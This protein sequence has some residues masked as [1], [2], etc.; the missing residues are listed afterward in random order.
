M[1]PYPP[2]KQYEQYAQSLLLHEQHIYSFWAFPIHI[3]T[4]IYTR[5]TFIF[6]KLIGLRL[7]I[8]DTLQKTATIHC[9]DF[10]TYL[11]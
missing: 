1:R 8:F 9:Q 11:R 10:R 3:I 7:Y 6:A 5:Q 4:R 2:M